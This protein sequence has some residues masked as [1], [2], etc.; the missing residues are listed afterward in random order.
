MERIFSAALK[1]ANARVVSVYAFY[2]INT[3]GNFEKG[4]KL[5]NQAVDILPGEPQY[6]KNLIN[7]LMVMARL[8]EAE[9]RLDQFKALKLV[10]SSEDDYRTLQE[11]ID[12]IRVERSRSGNADTGNS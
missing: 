5:F 11:D 9:Q 12:R 3:R 2:T 7:L 8:D 10:G 4:L 1:S 6:W